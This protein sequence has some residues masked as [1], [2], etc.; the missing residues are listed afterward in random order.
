MSIS[1]FVTG[2]N[3]MFIVDMAMIMPFDCVYNLDGRPIVVG[4]FASNTIGDWLNY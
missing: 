1:F 3:S 4:A 2:L